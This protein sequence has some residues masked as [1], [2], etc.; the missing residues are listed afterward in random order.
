MFANLSPRVQDIVLRSAGIV[1]LITGWLCLDSMRASLLAP[2]RH[3]AGAVEFLLGAM[4]F[5][6]FS[7]GSAL[8]TLGRHIFDRVPISARW[9]HPLQPAEDLRAS[10]DAGRFEA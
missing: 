2:P 4:T 7:T 1:L 3:D 8:L 9:A 10:S 6:G 5:L